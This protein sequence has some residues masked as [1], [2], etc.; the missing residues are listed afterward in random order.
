MENEGPIFMIRALKEYRPYVRVR[1]KG[2]KEN[3]L[4]I[5]EIK[6]TPE[7]AEHLAKHRAEFVKITLEFIDS[8][9]ASMVRAPPKEDKISAD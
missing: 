9:S 1:A 7:H 8:E 4:G 3:T 5:G 6:I 2:A